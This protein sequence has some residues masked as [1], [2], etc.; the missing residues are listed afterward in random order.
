[1]DTLSKKGKKDEEWISDFLTRGV[2]EIIE[3]DSVRSKFESGTI[4]RVKHGV[5][6][7]T[8][9]LH[10]GYWVVYR[11]LRKLQEMVH[12]I[13]LLIGTFT[14]QFG[15]PS[16]K[17]EVRKE[18]TADEVRE[19]AGDYVKQLAKIL[20]IQK[21]TVYWN[22]DWFGNMKL[23]DF[24]RIA[25]HFSV[26]RLLE[27]DMFV[28]RKKLGKEIKAPELMYPIL[29]AYDSVE[30]K[31]DLT[32]V[33]SDQLF[34]EI[35]ARNL[36]R[37][38]KE[39]PQD[40]I[41]LE[42]LVG[43]D[44]EK[45]MSQSL[46]N[47]INIDDEPHEKFGKIMSMPDHLIPHYFELLTDKSYKEIEAMKEGMKRGELNPKDLKEEL[48]LVLITE[49]DGKEAA[50]SAQKHFQ[51]VFREKGVPE[52][53]KSF[54]VD[55]PMILKEIVFKSGLSESMSEAQRFIEQGAV[56]LEG[57]VIEDWKLEVYKKESI[58]LRVGKRKFIKL[59]F[60]K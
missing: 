42:V 30:L 46:G 45:K 22:N 23:G 19:V 40:I 2:K 54:V 21:L 53:M 34:N 59:V 8:S 36:Q 10:F 27:R 13:Q 55:K 16:G 33:G 9:K 24:F 26:W 41:A 5:D 35:Q 49:L 11:K 7:T 48:A 25:N 6:P 57:K 14:A 1:M 3:E 12:T 47:V 15:D 28:E 56:T 32:I 17:T 38:Y 29:Q 44:G 20:D 43:L 50:E 37:A 39:E 31:S 18:R 4:L 60:N 51:K 52:S 58:I